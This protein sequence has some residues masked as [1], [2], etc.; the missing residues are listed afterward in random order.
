MR[1]QTQTHCRI[2]FYFFFESEL[3]LFVS[4]AQTL[5]IKGNFLMC[6]SGTSGTHTLRHLQPV[7]VRTGG[8]QM[9]QVRCND[10]ELPVASGR[11]KE[12]T[13]ES[14][15]LYIAISL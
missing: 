13:M 5:I 2:F 7:R 14:L 4:A 12:L 3:S 11:R 6:S 15:R 1:A 10:K 9:A 8:G